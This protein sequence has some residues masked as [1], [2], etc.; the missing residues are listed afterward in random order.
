MTERRPH[1]GAIEPSA[2]QRAVARSLYSLY[3]ALVN[4][5]FTSD[6]ALAIVG[7]TVTA[8]VLGGSGGDTEG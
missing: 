6:Q 4:T 3:V 8:A 7:Q 2:D 1:T 5:G